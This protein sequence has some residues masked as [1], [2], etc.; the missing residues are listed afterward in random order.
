MRYFMTFMLATILAFPVSA[1]H[2]DAGINLNS[3]VTLEGTITGF[4]WRNPHVYFT[5]ETMDGR[6]ERVE[7]TVQMGSA[8]TS[9]R[10]GW[11]RDSLSAGDRVTVQAYPAQDGHPYGILSRSAGSLERAGEIIFTEGLYAAEATATPSSLEGN[12]MTNHPLNP[13]TTG[14]FF[15]AELRLTE[16][17][18]AARA[19]YDEFSYENPEASCIGRPPPAAIIASNLFAMQIEINEEEELVVIRSEFWDEERTV[20]MDGRTHPEDSERFPSGHSIGWWD[21]GALVVDTANFANHRSPYQ[22][23]VPSGNQKHVVERYRLN[24]EGTRMIVEFTLE[25]PEYIAES[26]THSRELIY[27]PQVE[28]SSY[29]CDP[30]AARR[31]MSD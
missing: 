16:K 21:G 10:R 5:V 7:W 22:M 11:T 13:L 24:G 17:G 18:V 9:A 29:D 25:D 20:Y 19:A 6:G 1:H 14:R 12:W 4:Y 31:F 26:L 2:S 3:L 23:G 27:S 8:I 15:T 28:L 30:E